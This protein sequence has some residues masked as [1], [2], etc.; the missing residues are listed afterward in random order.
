[1]AASYLGK[2]TNSFVKMLGAPN[3][4]DIRKY[5]N[6]VKGA[7]VIVLHAGINNLIRDKYTTSAIVSNLK[8]AVVSLREA[9][10]GTKILLS[11]AAPL[12]ERGLEIEKSII[13]YDGRPHILLQE[14]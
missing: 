10:P 14:L 1:M 13:R 3:I 7:K 2:S 4:H 8:E 11:K 9:T 5:A 12:G 6:D